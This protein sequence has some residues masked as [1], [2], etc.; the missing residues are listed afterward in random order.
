MT[1]IYPKFRAAAVQVAPIYLNLEATVQ[2]SCELID[3]A[4]SNG[5]KLVAF[6]EAFLPGYPWFAF[7]GH[8]EYTRK[9]YHE[10]Y[11][12]AVEIPSLAIQKISEAAKGM[13]RTFVYHAVKKMAA[14]SI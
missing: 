13:K 5:A 10:L 2:K 1:S 7:I 4:A 11:K 3:E 14:L 6:P 8:P 12:N 9:F